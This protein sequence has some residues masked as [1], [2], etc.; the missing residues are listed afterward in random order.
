MIPYDAIT[1]W[2]TQRPWPTRD[3]VE[4]DLL[5]SRAICEIANHPYL[6]DELI[7]RGG[8]A[9][10]KLHLDTPLRYSEDLDYV[11]RT[12]GGIEPVTS[13]LTDLGQQ[14]G[15]TVST[16]ISQ[17]P[18]VLWRTQAQSGTTLKI[19][20][21]ITTNERTPALPL[22]YLPHDVGSRW[23]NGSATVTTFQVEELVATKIR[24]LYQRRKGRDVFDLWLALERLALDP[25]QILNAFEPYRPDTLTAKSAISNLRQKLTHQGFRDDLTPLVRDL[26]SDYDID[27]A[28]ELI[29]AALLASLD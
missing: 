14:L 12:P 11:R 3:Q 17:Q 16:R 20:I 1:E 5:L 25:T 27:Q 8:T 9:F 18:K 26:P 23:W 28:A 29:I 21:E 2:A 10:H 7:F 4:Q 24:A 6:K 22:L 13:A 15:L 19:K